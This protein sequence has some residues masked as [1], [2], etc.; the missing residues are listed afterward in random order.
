MPKLLTLGFTLVELLAVVVILGIILVIAVPRIT[1]II[2]NT[3]KQAFISSVRFIISSVKYKIQ[4]NESTSNVFVMYV[5]GE[6]NIFP[7]NINIEYS[8]E[9]PKEGGIIYTT[10]GSILYA[11]YDGKYC[12]SKNKY[13]A[14]IVVEQI[15]SDSCVEKVIYVQESEPF[16]NLFAGESYIKT[17]GY[18]NNSGIEITLQNNN[19]YFISYNT[20]LIAGLTNPASRE[21]RIVVPSPTFRIGLATDGGYYSRK[22]LYNEETKTANLYFYGP[23]IDED[24][25]QIMEWRNITIINLNNIGYENLNVQEIEHNINKVWFDIIADI[26]KRFIHN[27]WISY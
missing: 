1:D 14:E 17:T 4:S 2:E 23:N 6:K 20:K 27:E 9:N 15:S 12:V 5:D 24:Q 21:I 26:P 10:D 7:T 3:Q 11:L 19:N 25:G 13:S 16:N 22:F 8:G 18:A